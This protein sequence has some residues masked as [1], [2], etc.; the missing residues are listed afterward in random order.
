MRLRALHRFVFLLLCLVSLFPAFASYLFK[1]EQLSHF[2]F[3]F[4][5]QKV[6]KQLVLLMI[7][8]VSIQHSPTC[9][10]EIP[11]L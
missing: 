11:I 8:L 6:W 5:E 9:F 3:F 2:F 7:T 1:V 4:R 10:W